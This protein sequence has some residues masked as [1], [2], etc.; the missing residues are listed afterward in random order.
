MTLCAWNSALPMWMTTSHNCFCLRSSS[1]T[2]NA[3]ALMFVEV[4]SWRLE[5]GA[6]AIFRSASAR[7]SALST[8]PARR[9]AAGLLEENWKPSGALEFAIFAVDENKLVSFP[10]L[11][12]APRPY[13]RRRAPHIIG[14]VWQV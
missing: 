12:L 1:N 7:P 11:S 8:R 6:S 3:N 4:Y 5:A 14:K 10:Y 2:L 9:E 13:R